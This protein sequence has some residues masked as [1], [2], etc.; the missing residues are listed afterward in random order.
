M[1]GPQVVIIGGGI[2]GASTADELSE[3]GWTNVTLVDAGTLPAAGGSTSHAPGV[4]FQT[5]GTKVMSDLAMYT[6][7]KFTALQWEDEPCY[8]AVG[9]LEIAT[10]PERLAELNRRFGY[11]QSWGIPDA[12]LLSAE[13]AVHMWD[14]LNPEMVLG[15]LF[16]PTDGIAKA[17]NAVAAQVE[18]ARSRGVTIKDNCEVL[19]ILVEAGKVT[20]V[21]TS[22][23]FLP[24][25]IVLCCAGIWGPK[26]AK[27]VGM[28]LP[29]TPLAHQLAWTKPLPSLTGH[30]REATRPVLRHQDADLYYRENFEGIAIGSYRHRPMPL[31][32]EELLPWGGEVM[33]SVLPFTQEDFEFPLAETAALIPSAVRIEAQG[34]EIAEAINGVFSFTTDNLPLLGPSPDVEGFWVAEAVWVTHS[35]GVGKAM[36]EWIIDGHCSSFDLHALDVNRFERHQLA[37]AYVLAKDCQNFVEVYDILHPLQPMEHSRP[38]RT[39]PFYMR[40]IELGGQFL[41]ASGWERPQWYTANDDLVRSDRNTG[42]HV[43]NPDPWSAMFSSPTVAAEAAIT[44]NDVA[45]Y[46]MTALK[47]LEVSG[48]GA[49]DFLQGL[50][51][52]NI[53]KTVGGVTYCLML[54]TDGGIRS[55]ITVARLETELYQ[56]GANGAMDID[57]LRRH[58]PANSPIQIRDITAGTCCIGIWGPKAR[59]V[60]Q[61]LTSTDFSNDGFTYFRSKQ[62]YLGAVEVTA[63]RLSYVGELGWELYTTADQ[64]LALWDLLMKTGAPHGIIAAGR[65]AFNSLRIEKGYRSF[66]TDMTFEHDP[67][68]AGLA[69]AVKLDKGDFIG[70][71]A[72]I[73]RAKH[74]TRRL[75]LLA[76]ENASNTAATDALVLGNEPVYC[77]GEPVGY[78]TSAAYSYTLGVSLALAW[79]PV[80]LT[81]PGTAV[82]VGYFEHR[83]SAV[84]TAEPGFDPEMKKIRC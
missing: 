41:E 35:A 55:D 49:T 52:A 38:L 18:R 54:D 16:V 44:R 11:A 24:A 60:V 48:P 2:V 56:I 69:F 12:R 82:E 71:E 51:T 46:D 58:L 29:L 50:V 62:A 76:L 13:E 32:A 23:G 77:S 8:L 45:I 22:T 20:G 74:V 7:E 27:M 63:M 3:R 5:N 84:V 6:V 59:D 4:V 70:R 26:I 25:D 9:G 31:T 80:A 36:A 64:G 1:A 10:T 33:P 57:W 61:S 28:A 21:K 81:E 30:T 14:L 19:D 43:P 67:Y 65:G 39:S 34:I 83:Y 47:R 42:W 78:V 17:V 15:G 72:L 73:E 53:A 40:E 75:V 66:G 37:P 68:E 79:L